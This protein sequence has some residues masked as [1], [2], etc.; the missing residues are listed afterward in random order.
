MKKI[1]FFLALQSFIFAASF[2]S[3]MN[4]I[5]NAI[6]GT[7]GKSIGTLIIIALGLYIAKNHDRLKDIW[8]T[9]LLVFLGICLALN[10]KTIV[11]YFF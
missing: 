7:V 8:L 6:T 4:T 3:V 9:C 5:L 11:N 1:L 2:E 10:A